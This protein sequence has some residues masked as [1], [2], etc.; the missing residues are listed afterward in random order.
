MRYLMDFS[1]NGKDF[2]GYQKQIKKRTVEEEIEKVLTSINDNEVV[3]YSSGRTDKGVNALHQK[4]HF[5]LDK[6]ITVYKLKYA[7]NRLLPEDIYI[8]DLEIVSDDFHAR[9]NAKKKTYEYKINIG[10]YSVLEKDFIYQYCKDLDFEKMKYAIK[11]FVG[12]HDFTSFVSAEDKRENKIRTIYNA[13]V[14]KKKD[15]ITIS[16]TGNGFLKYQ[17]RNMVGLLIS[18]GEN[19]Y[20]YERIIELFELKDRKKASITAPACGLTLINV[21][22]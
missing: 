4:A 15:I 16:I 9:Y 12:T 7:L 11:Y 3:I 1:Y 22:Y 13:K 2:N 8:N 20:T 10:K 21:K 5:D 6:N 19:K 17:I 14:K 18:I